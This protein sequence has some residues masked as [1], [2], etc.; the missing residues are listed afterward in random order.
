[1]LEAPESA[2][3]AKL[4]LAPKNPLPYRQQLTAVR[5]LID[6]FQQLLDA[7]GPVTRIVLR[8]CESLS[9]PGPNGSPCT[10][11][12]SSESLLIR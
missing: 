11:D 1:M 6:G 10:A 7:G 9:R 3:V 4:P 8:A 12:A 2:D 5:S